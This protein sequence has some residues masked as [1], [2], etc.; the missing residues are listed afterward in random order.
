MRSECRED[1]LIVLIIYVR[2]SVGS[3]SLQAAE[4]VEIQMLQSKYIR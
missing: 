3:Q 4:D 1:F 2:K